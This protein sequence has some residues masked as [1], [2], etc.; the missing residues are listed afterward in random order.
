MRNK[1]VL[2]FLLFDIHVYIY[3][4]TFGVAVI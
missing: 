1:F 2:E 3:I 4:C